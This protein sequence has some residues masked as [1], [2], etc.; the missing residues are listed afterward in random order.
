MANGGQS[1][2]DDRV[3]QLRPADDRYM[4]DVAERIDRLPSCPLREIGLKLS[5][6]ILPNGMRC[7]Y[8]LADD[9]QLADGV[10]HIEK[11]NSDNPGYELLK[12]WMVMPDSSIAVLRNIFKSW[13]REDLV[14]LIDEARRGT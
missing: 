8:K 14:R 4:I 11:M 12:V 5:K 2:G 1:T 10:D 7:L 9:L 13:K 6:E 3:V